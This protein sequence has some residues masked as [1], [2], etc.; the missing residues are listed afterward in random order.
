MALPINRLNVWSCLWKVY[1][2]WKN[3]FNGILSFYLRIICLLFSRALI[4]YYHHRFELP[5]ECELQD[6]IDDGRIT[7]RVSGLT[8]EHG[9]LEN[10]SPSIIPDDLLTIMNN[11]NNT[12][13][14]CNGFDLFD[15]PSNLIEESSS[16][17]RY[18][19]LYLS[20]SNWIFIILIKY[21]YFNFI[22]IAFAQGH[23]A[24]PL[25]FNDTS[26]LQSSACINQALSIF[27][28]A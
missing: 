22:S 9:Q 20:V 24:P 3:F 23:S 4:R 2:L 10:A 21:H 28:I 7:D 26:Q 14:N 12:N 15:T 1:F 17:Q 8:L 6:W 11:N 25:H 27:T 13:N 5:D 18:A 19:C 16:G